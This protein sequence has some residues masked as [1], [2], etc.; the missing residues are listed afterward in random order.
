[1]KVSNAGL[2]SLAAIGLSGSHVC[3]EHLR[4]LAVTTT[5]T[6]HDPSHRELL[7]KTPHCPT[8]KSQFFDTLAHGNNGWSSAT[9]TNF[10]HSPD[11]AIGPFRK[12]SSPS[13]KTDDVTS[14]KDQEDR[15]VQFDIVKSDS[16]D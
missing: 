1:M 14:L 15:R 4:G 11:V 3:A 12:G 8:G 10:R 16:W 9:H 6:D 13:I 5:T 7:K 2:S